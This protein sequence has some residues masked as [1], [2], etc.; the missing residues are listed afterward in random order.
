VGVHACVR[1][2]CLSA[3]DP[4]CSTL[5]RIDH[6]DIGTHTAQLALWFHFSPVEPATLVLPTFAVRDRSLSRPTGSIV[7]WMTYSRKCVKTWRYD[8]MQAEVKQQQQ[9]LFPTLTTAPSNGRLV[10]ILSLRHPSQSSAHN[11]TVAVA[12]VNN[13]HTLHSLVL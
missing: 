1:A 6:G 8:R 11:S 3:C 12:F 5:F 13:E 9:Q 10:T 7:E 2:W 4:R